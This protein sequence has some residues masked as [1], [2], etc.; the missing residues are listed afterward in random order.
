MIGSA[1]NLAQGG[2]RS[3]VQIPGYNQTSIHAH[4]S[5]RSGSQVAAV[6]FDF[7]LDCT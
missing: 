4:S 1:S 7:C 6:N 3:N 2:M 5:S